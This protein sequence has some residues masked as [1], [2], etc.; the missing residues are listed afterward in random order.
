MNKESGVNMN[1]VQFV[2]LRFY[3]DTNAVS[4]PNSRMTTLCRHPVPP[5]LYLKVNYMPYHC[6][7]T[8]HSNGQ[9]YPSETE[10]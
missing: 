6:T 1:F 4:S 10:D 3:P 8:R 9:L 5:L 7:I 2:G